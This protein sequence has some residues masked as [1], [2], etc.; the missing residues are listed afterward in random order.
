M[1]PAPFDYLRAR[2]LGEAVRA[3]ADAAGDG[4]I[5][6]G[7][8]SLMPVLALRMARP[9]LLVDIN[10][11]PGLST[12]TPVD[13][14]VRLGALV[15]HARLV[16]QTLHPLL[17]EAARW[18][19]H[20]AI[21]S[22]GTSGGSIAH[23]DPAAELP[24]VAAALEATIHIAGPGGTRTSTATDLFTGPLE[25]TLAEDEL[26][27]AIDMPAPERWGFAEF[28]RRHGDFGLVTVVAAEVRGR[29]R[30][31]IGGVGGV[32]H[33][34]AEAE[35]LLNDGGSPDQVAAAAAAAVTPSGDIHASAEYRRAMME[36]F[37]RRALTAATQKAVA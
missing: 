11:I 21:R 6:A 34:P 18:I 7:G 13:T 8:Q 33:R 31:A 3:L 36:E 14:G 2:S 35:D 24:V 25:T 23:A 30:L 20:A 16:E 29:W 4:K 9:R 5:I 1:K 28:S 26:I 10:R 32:P 27:T 37:T 12:I 19:G 22:R 15:R 17:A